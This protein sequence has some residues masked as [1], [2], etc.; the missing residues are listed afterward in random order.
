MAI[1]GITHASDAVRPGDL[2]AALPGANAHG[3][4]FIPA[5]A[6]AGAVAVLTD[7]AGAAAAA[8]AGLPADGRD[9]PRAVLGAS[10][11]RCTAIRPAG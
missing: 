11:P 7:A 5:A 3:A 6:R 2:F 9:D 4:R 1:T 8:D 10:P